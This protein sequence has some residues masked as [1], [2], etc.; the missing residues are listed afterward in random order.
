MGF[1]KIKAKTNLSTMDIGAVISESDFATLTPDGQFVQLEYVEEDLK[2]EPF[3]VK[4]GLWSIQKAMGGL[5][6]HPTSFVRDKILETFVHTKDVSDRIDC[7][8]RNLHVYKEEGIEVPKRGMLLYGAPGGGKTTLIN[9]ICDEYVK[10]GKTA[11]IVWTT[12]KFESYQVKDFIKSFEYVGVE[13][14]ILVVEDIGGVEVQNRRQASDSSLLSLLDNQEKT[15][16]IP[17]LILATTNYPENF[18]GNL[19]NR[20]QRFDDKIKVGFPDAS[21]R[22]ELLRFFGKDRVKDTDLK[23]ISS[24]KCKEFT[25]A[26]IKEIVIRSRIYEKNMFDVINDMVKEMAQVTNSFEDPRG[27]VGF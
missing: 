6:L 16:T 26:H 21:A 5:T 17:I 7:F 20:P 15:F 18:M 1:F 3:R 10:D 23:L 4:P 22:L 27:P 25:P 12:D 13:K 2:L 14:L 19:T 24:D 9:K 8:F 11:V